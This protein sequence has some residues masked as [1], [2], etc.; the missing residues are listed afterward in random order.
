MK[1]LALLALTLLSVNA[2]AAVFVKTLVPT[3]LMKNGWEFQSVKVTNI[4]QL[5]DGTFK[6]VEKA[7]NRCVK[8]RRNF[9][10][11]NEYRDAKHG[12]LKKGSL[13]LFSAATKQSGYCA[14]YGR[15]NDGDRGCIRIAYDTVV[16]PLT[17][18]IQKVKINT[19]GGDNRDDR[20]IEEVLSTSSFTIPACN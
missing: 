20:V 15:D 7:T 12:C 1:K 9:R 4:C 19:K 2:S 10:N 16:K 18:T 8:Y 14:E 5:E 3:M 13:H 11:A 6:T 17:Y